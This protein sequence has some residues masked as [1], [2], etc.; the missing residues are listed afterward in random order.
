MNRAT[1]ILS[2]LL[3]TWAQAQAETLSTTET[4]SETETET[5]EYEPISM[6]VNQLSN[7]AVDVSDRTSTQLQA[8]IEQA[9]ANVMDNVEAVTTNAMAD[10]S[11]AIDDTNHLLLGNPSCNPAWNMQEFTL[12]V[13]EQLGACTLKLSNTIETY[14]R[15]GQQ[16]LANVQSFVQQM[17]QLPMLCSSQLMGAALAPLGANYGDNNNCFLRGMTT[18]NQGLAQAMHSGSLLLVNTRRLPQDQM[19][20][21]Q[22]CSDAVAAKVIEYLSV[23]RANCS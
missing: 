5:T 21:A 16:V 20:E 6:V 11:I 1:G 22:R 19:A 13:T 23:Q 4:Y 14:R 17:A 15:D 8:N 9:L 2:I 7:M 10:I 12:N 3:L 18:I